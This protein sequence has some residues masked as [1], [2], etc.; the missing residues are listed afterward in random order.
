L[1]AQTPN[2]WT[3]KGSEYV[4]KSEI[5]NEQDIIE[6]L[7]EW[8]EFERAVYLA[9]F[10]IPKGKVSTYGRIAKMIGRPKA[11]RAVAN[12]LHNNPLW[13]IVP[14]QRV[15]CSDGRFGG[16]RDA[17]AGRRKQVEDEGVPIVNGR[18]A[19]TKDVLF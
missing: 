14:C 4:D 1:A 3:F 5:K 11:S 16:P 8:S 15:V 7:R 10:K 12:T 2:P 17:A 13:P 18:V 19:M 6:Y 9:T